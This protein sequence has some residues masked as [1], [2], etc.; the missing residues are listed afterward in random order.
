MKKRIIFFL[1][2]VVLSACSG[3]SHRPMVDFAA[4]PGKTT[5]TYEQDLADCQQYAESVSSGRSTAQGAAGGAALSGIISGV[6]GAIIGSDVGTSAAA[7]AA[8][9][10]IGG[11]AGGAA[12]A[13]NTQQEIINNCMRG[14][15]YSVLH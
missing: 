11:G 2:A 13:A 10:A 6:F 3:K 14:R 7:G 5:T 8:A 12:S 1:L 4:S 9:G 15:G